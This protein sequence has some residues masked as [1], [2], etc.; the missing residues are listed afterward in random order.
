MDPDILDQIQRILLTVEEKA[1]IAAQQNHRE[2]MLVECSLSLF[3]RLLMNKPYNKKVAKNLFHF[4]WK[5]GN[6]LKIIDV[7]NGVYQLHF[8]LESQLQWIADNGPWRFNNHRLVVRR[9]E[10]GMSTQNITF[11]SISLSVQV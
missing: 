6:D 8:K 5:L 11:P 7:G 3:G 1:D 4:V 10:K 9:W 2:R